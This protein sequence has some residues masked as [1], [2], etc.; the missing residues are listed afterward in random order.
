MLHFR[1]A[2][3]GIGIAPAKQEAVFEAFEQADASTTR[4][5]G[6]TGLGLAISRTLVEP[7]GGRIWVES[8]RRDLAAETPGPGCAFHFTAAFCLGQAPAQSAL[9]LL[10]G[11][12]ILVVDDDRTNRTILVE[13]LR[14]MGMKPVAV[15]T[16]EAA[17]A[18][19]EQALAVGSPFPLAI[20]DFQAP[21]RDGLTLASR[22]RERAELRD[23]RLFILTSAGRRG[24]V[25]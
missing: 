1:V 3:T 9:A 22:I 15:E 25:A 18:M 10:D 8:P 20:L 12:P 7:M 16:G 13:M 19:L 5:Y 17:L 21:G 23:T 11:E 6:G 4:K 24:E 2:D 14:T